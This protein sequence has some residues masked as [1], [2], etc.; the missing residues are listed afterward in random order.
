MTI[1]EEYPIVYKC[2]IPT[3]GHSLMGD[4]IFCTTKHHVPGMLQP[5]RIDFFHCSNCLSM[6][7]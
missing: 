3:R 1:K 5:S 7:A 4:V 2:K 6:S